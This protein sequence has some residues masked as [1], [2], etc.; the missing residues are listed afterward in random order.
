MS[1]KKEEERGGQNSVCILIQ[2]YWPDLKPNDE[3]SGRLYV[4]AHPRQ[5]NRLVGRHTGLFLHPT[6]C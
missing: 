3:M 1:Q 5:A 4:G 2:S 6:V